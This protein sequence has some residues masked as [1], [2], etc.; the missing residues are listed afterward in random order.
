MLFPLVAAT[1]SKEVQLVDAAWKAA[2]HGK[3]EV[4]VSDVLSSRA[5]DGEWANDGECDEKLHCSGSEIP[6]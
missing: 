1:T 2:D 4:V 5:N 6:V 3:D